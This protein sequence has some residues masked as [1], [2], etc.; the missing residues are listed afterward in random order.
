M[1]KV[2]EQDFMRDGLSEDELKALDGATPPAEEGSPVDDAPK[3]DDRPRDEHGRFAK[4]EEK[5]QEE[6]KMVDV[7][8][9]QE[10]RA[11]EREL[12]DKYSRLEERTNIILQQM[13]SKKEPPKAPEKPDPN[14]DIF[15]Y[16]KWLEEQ[17]GA[18]ERRLNEREQ[19]E[20]QSRQQ[21]EQEARIWGFWQD[22]C[23]AIATKQ[24]DFGEAAK[25]LSDVRVKQLEAYAAVD[26][27]FENPR[28]IHAEIDNE[29]RHIIATAAQ[30]QANPAEAV[31]KLALAFGYQP[32]QQE[33]QKPK[34]PEAIR[35]LADRQARHQSLSGIQGGAAP[36]KLD[37][38]GLALMSDADF[39][40]LMSTASG[41]AEIEQ[42]MGLH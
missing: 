24:P 19:T 16:S 7:R 27:R 18:L 42:I 30:R 37:A 40:K 5:P 38:K 3:G 1:A 9:L 39:K 6:P 36:A 2:S 28:A 13:E 29:L 12:R 8:A 41:R 21:S 11:A 20:T 26:P 22:S 35:E 14:V 25:F 23:R 34:G 33:Q 17:H 4:P 10:A 32:G 31:Y 15:A